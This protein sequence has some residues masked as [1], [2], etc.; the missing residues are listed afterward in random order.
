MKATRHLIFSLIAT[1]A[2]FLGSVGCKR[3][4]HNTTV[5]VEDSVR[6]YFPIRQGEQLSILYKIENTGK[7]PLM[8][9]D[10][11]TSCGCVILEQDAKRLV[12]PGGMSYLHLNYNSRKNVGEVSHQIRIYGNI[13]PNG[14]KELSFVVN[15]VPDPDYTRDYEQMYRQN[16]KG[17]IGDIVDGETRDKGYFIKGYYPEEVIRTPRTEERDELNPLK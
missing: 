2:V 12:P 5:Y 9:Q 7:D 10:I 6:H 8:I 11:H 15:V 1:C 4:I 16:Q 13:E 17:I 3:P 14:M